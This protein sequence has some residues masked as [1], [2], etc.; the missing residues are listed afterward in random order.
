MLKRW[1]H[2]CKC[3]YTSKPFS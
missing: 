3:P 2:A 1:Q